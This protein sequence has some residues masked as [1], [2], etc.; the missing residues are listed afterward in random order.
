MEIKKGKNG[1]VISYTVPLITYGQPESTEIRTIA[2]YIVNNVLFVV[3][4]RN[5]SETLPVI[6]SEDDHL[7]I[8]DEEFARQP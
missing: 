4:F 8:G 5:H 2:G 1:F 3:A 7:I 6:I